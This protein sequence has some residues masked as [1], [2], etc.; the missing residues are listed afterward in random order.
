MALFEA[1]G[2]E[3][4][5]RFFLKEHTSVSIHCA[6]IGKVWEPLF[7]KSTL[8]RLGAKRPLYSI[9]IFWRSELSCLPLSFPAHPNLFL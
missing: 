2:E 6:R 3:N 8:L 9:F 7:S 5:V 4:P 1:V